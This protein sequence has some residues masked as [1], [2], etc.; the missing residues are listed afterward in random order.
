MT[1]S[2]SGLRKFSAFSPLHPAAPTSSSASSPPANAES[3]VSAHKLLE[4]FDLA[5]LQTKIFE[6][7]GYSAV[8][9]PEVASPVVG[10]N[11]PPASSVASA[12][13]LPAAVAASGKAPVDYIHFRVRANGEAARRQRLKDLYFFGT[14]EAVFWNLTVEEEETMLK[15]PQITGKPSHSV[16]QFN[17][18]PGASSGLTAKDR[19][20]LT[21]DLER[22]TR[23]QV[24]FS[25][26][27]IRGLKVDRVES[28][29]SRM[30]ERIRELPDQ[31]RS[32]FRGPP[33]AEVRRLTGDLL[34]LRVQI[35]FLSDLLDGSPDDY[36]ED[37]ELYELFAA[38]IKTL[39]VS[40]RLE[41][42]NT[43]L[44][45]AI[46]VLQVVLHDQGHQHLQKLEL[47]V[48]VLIAVAI[49]ALIANPTMSHH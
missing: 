2:W 33:I 18:G 15:L 25:R 4:Q 40:Q 27:M 9:P 14:G 44:N 17:F 48:A 3:R 31:I 45:Y 49:L 8:D 5:A 41:V 30:L 20:I 16:E 43:R 11:R 37:P 46:D 10:T 28:E 26:G 6:V 39:E 47:L 35:N 19:I 7:Y 22:R 24:A 34:G 32:N 38:M 21:D 42:V 13:R 29:T 1:C 23:H 36:W 12:S